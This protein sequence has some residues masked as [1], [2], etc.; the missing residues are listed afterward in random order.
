VNA[1][2]NPTKNGFEIEIEEFAKCFGT[3]DFAKGTQAFLN[4]QKPN[5]RD[6]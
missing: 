3:T 6:K 2:A 5:F 1:G 4:K